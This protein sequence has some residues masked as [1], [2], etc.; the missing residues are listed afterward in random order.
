MQDK[1]TFSEKASNWLKNSLTIRLFTI[2]ILILLLLIPVSMVESLI[3]ERQYRQKESTRE[4]SSKWGESQTIIGLVL[5]VPYNTYNKVY[6]SE[7]KKYKLIKSRE[8]AHFLPDQLNISGEVNP[9]VRYRGIYE[10]IVYNSKLNLTGNF[11]HPNFKEWNITEENILWNEAFVS[12]G[13]SDLRGLQNKV[14][15][16]W[17]GENFDFNPGI[18]SNDVINN[19]ISCRVPVKTEKSKG[20]TKNFSLELN[21]NGSSDLN[22]T[23]IGKSTNIKLTSPWKSPS[24][25]GAFLPDNRNIHNKG[26]DAEWDVLHLN[27]SYPQS[28]RGTTRGIH[29]SS[30]G[31]NLIVPVDEYQK[32]MRSAKYAVMFITLT[33]LLFFFVQVLNHIRIHPIQYIIVGLALCVFYTLLVALSE[34]I[35]FKFSY[36]ISGISIVSM[37]TLYANS[38]AKNR[39]LTALIGLILVLLYLFIYSIIQMQDYALLMGSVGLFLVLATI[40]YLSRK[41]D[42]YTISPNKNKS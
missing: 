5:T 4:V 6:D 40:M 41:I 26:F 13:L 18:E 16:N 24:F 27:R 23:P 22:F 38:I 34:H 2:G 7:N 37:I 12:L 39:R 25:N 9:E 31:V 20:L 42:W 33:F 30:F 10:I 19:G 29:Q 11:S 17:N 15:L 21:F 35:P 32:S 36:L 1:P 28:F 3:R 8:Y 14:S